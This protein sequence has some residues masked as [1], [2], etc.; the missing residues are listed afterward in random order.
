MIKRKDMQNI[1]S[2]FMLS[3]INEYRSKR[4]AAE[5][6]GSSV[7]TLNKYIGNLE[8]ELGLRLVVSSEHGCTLTPKGLSILKSTSLMKEIL[9]QIYGEKNKK[10]QNHYTVKVGMDIGISTNLIFYN[11]DTFFSRFPDIQIQSTIFQDCLKLQYNNLDIGISYSEPKE[12][13]V[14]ILDMKKIECKLFAAPA[15]LKKYGY[16]QNIKDIVKNHRIVCKS[17]YVYYDKQYQEILKSS[18]NIRYISNSSESVIDAVRHNAGICIMP[19]RY[20]EEGLVC[21]ENFDWNSHMNIYLFS[22]KQAKD[23]PGVRAVI[24]YFKEI[25]KKM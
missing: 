2:L 15:Y 11:I 8:A 18:R 25:F 16:P 5:A 9:L 4:K 6:I 22:R 19:A 24:N 17:D 12:Q 10:S 3:S 1:E 21:L 14:I 23:L 7:D 20:A 13:D